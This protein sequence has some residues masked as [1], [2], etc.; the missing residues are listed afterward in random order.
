MMARGRFAIGSEAE[1]VDANAECFPDH[2]SQS[3]GADVEH[4]CR[5]IDKLSLTQ[6]PQ[7]VGEPWRVESFISRI[8]AG[9][10]SEV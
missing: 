1:R 6:Q 8:S 4:A 9:C 10:I 7:E 3:R 2:F 5:G